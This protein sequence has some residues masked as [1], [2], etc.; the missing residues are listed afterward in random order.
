MNYY[1]LL[2]L[3]INFITILN[4]NIEALFEPVDRLEPFAAITQLIVNSAL[5]IQLHAVTKITDFI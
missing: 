3:F 1:L 4:R 5:T 2:N